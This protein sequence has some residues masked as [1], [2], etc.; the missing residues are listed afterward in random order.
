MGE[1]VED[2]DHHFIESLDESEECTSEQWSQEFDRRDKIMLRQMFL[3]GR[4]PRRGP[5]DYLH[6]DLTNQIII[7]IHLIEVFD[8]Y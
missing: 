3:M 7:E 2:R 6:R 1:E 4:D 8:M 5:D